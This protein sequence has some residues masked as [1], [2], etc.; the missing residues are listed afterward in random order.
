MGTAEESLVPW[1]ALMQPSHST[2]IRADSHLYAQ[3]VVHK[4]ELKHCIISQL[5]T[6]LFLLFLRSWCHWGRRW[7][8]WLQ[9]ITIDT[10]PGKCLPFSSFPLPHQATTLMIIFSAILCVF[11]IE[12]KVLKGLGVAKTGFR[13]FR[14]RTIKQY[15]KVAFVLTYLWYIYFLMSL[16]NNG[17]VYE[18]RERPG[19]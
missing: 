5:H 1:G 7:R 9:T 6:I 16:Q 13:L 11:Q 19:P 4:L 10:I 17:I 8:S 15:S 18:K 3:D 14:G 12:V 2:G